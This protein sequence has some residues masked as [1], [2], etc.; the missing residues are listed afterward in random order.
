MR[1]V[2]SIALV[3]SLSLG[4]AAC[5]QPPSPPVTPKA[6]VSP[7]KAVAPAHV[8]T[9]L[10]PAV[11]A[12]TAVVGQ[13]DANG[14]PLVDPTK[15]PAVNPSDAVGRLLMEKYPQ[16]ALIS[17]EPVPGV[18]L[19]EIRAQ[20]WTD[21]TVGYTNKS[22]DYV[23][24]NGDLFLGSAGSIHNYTKEN[25][26]TRAYKLI[27]QLP[28]DRALTYTYGAGARKIVVFE[29]PDCPECQA[30][31]EDIKRIGP[32]LN[33]TVVV[34]PMPL[35]RVHPNAEQ[36]AR[37]LLCTTNPE[38]AWNEWMTN[39]DSRKDWTAFAAKYPANPN[40]PRAS[41]VDTMLVLGEQMGLNQT[42][43]IMFENG[44]VFKGRPTIDELEKSFQFVAA[45]QANGQGVSA[46]SATAV[47]PPAAAPQ[48]QPVAPALPPVLPPT[49]SSVPARPSSSLIPVH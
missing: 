36:H 20:Q 49:A 11:S 47:P 14:L 15:G 23:Y 31:E 30:L 18:D 4:L 5:N 12:T 46:P 13:D 44:M 34:I 32:A 37:Y 3:F 8:A 40:C 19:F 45:A 29:D 2:A 6:A 7:H 43:T 39:A 27:K 48:V 24:V 17:V 41:A 33:L 25:A 35:T 28:F 10:A 21:G 42:P 22:V 26:N 38:G 9:V 1:S 16:I